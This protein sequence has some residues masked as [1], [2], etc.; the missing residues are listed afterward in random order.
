MLAEQDIA[1]SD[2][3][4]VLGNSE[5]LVQQCARAANSRQIVDRLNSCGVGGFVEELEGGGGAILDGTAGLENEL[6]VH[7]LSG[8]AQSPAVTFETLL[9]PGS[10]WRAGQKGYTLVAQ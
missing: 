3:G 7:L 10:G 6:V 2:H 1:E 8:F 9:G 4:N 5:A